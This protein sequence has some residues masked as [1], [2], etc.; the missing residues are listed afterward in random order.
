MKIKMAEIILG[1]MIIDREVDEKMVSYIND[2]K[3]DIHDTVEYN[4]MLYNISDFDINL[5]L[6]LGHVAWTLHRVG[7]SSG[8]VVASDL[9]LKLQQ[10]QF[11]YVELICEKLNYNKLMERNEFHDIFAAIVKN[12]EPYQWK[13]KIVFYTN[14]QFQQIKQQ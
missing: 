3:F 4:S 5:S 10:V 13:F 8:Q 11:K 14:E 6:R 7:E 2:S 1:S 12:G 9:D